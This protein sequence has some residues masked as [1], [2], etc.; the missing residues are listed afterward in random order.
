M[1]RLQRSVPLYPRPGSA[2]EAQGPPRHTPALRPRRPRGPTSAA[3]SPR[4]PPR[5]RPPPQAQSHRPAPGRPAACSPAP[6]VRWALLPG[7]RPRP[8]LGTPWS[9]RGRPPRRSPLEP[10]P[11]PELP[12][13]RGEPRLSAP[14]LAPAL[15]SAPVGALVGP[16]H[17]PPSGSQ[18]RLPGRRRDQPTKPCPAP[19]AP[20]PRAVDDTWRRRAWRG[21]APTRR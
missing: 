7:R 6:F 14:A 5:P 17:Q 12:G 19:S 9:P 13:R 21:T 15:A 10:P 2:S 16:A 8:A 20:P 18:P 11:Q 1:T 4:P 3:S